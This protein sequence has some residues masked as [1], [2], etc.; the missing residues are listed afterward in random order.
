MKKILV[1]LL[2]TLA[3]FGREFRVASYN[4]ENLFDLRKSGSEYT[5]YIP[6]T[7]YGWDDKTFSIKVKNISRVIC[8]MKPDI[9]GLQEIENDDALRALQHGVKACGW[10]MIYRAIAD[11][12]AS[13]V[14][15][16]LLSKFP[17]IEK[18]EID[19]APGKL[20]YRN[21]LEVLVDISGHR[22]RLFVNHWKSRNGG[23]SMRI[24]SA[25]A[26]MKRLMQLPKDADYIILG[27]LNSNWNESRTIRKSPRLNDTGGRT[28][29]N[30]ILKTFCDGKPVTK[31]TIHWPCHVDLWLE[32]PPQRRWSHNFYG[33]KSS[34]DHMLLPAGMFD[35]KG[36]NYLDRSFHLFR[37][38]YLFMKNGSIFRWQIAKRRHGKHLDA[39]YSDHL[40]IYAMFTTKPFS[41]KERVEA[42]K[43]TLPEAIKEIHAHI[44]D[45][46][47]M[48]IGWTNVVIDDAAVIYK[49]GRV[50]IVKEKNGRAILVYGDTANLKNGHT[51]RLG[52]QK[53]YDYRGLREVTKLRVLKDLGK[54]DISPL[55]LKR[56]DDPK[57][58]AIVN[59]VVEKIE[60]VYR[61]G[62]LYFN[63]KKI[64]VY[65]HKG[66]KRPKSGEK[67][68]LCHV[69]I[70][71]YRNRPE[72]VVE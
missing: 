21:I 7:G 44:A 42:P 57:D 40:P 30:D 29:I 15:T 38:N 67:I 14:K 2:F 9:I 18:R 36:V 61:R 68:V 54:R 55:L 4:V 71:L 20:R 46:Y 62:Y 33:M 13:T 10:T 59:E 51:Y 56:I 37:P 35:A 41:L 3:L 53:I 69:R 17:I 5:E 52:I 60:G 22:V 32:L 47:T 50:A 12:K 1:F 48:P 25:K 27:D 58:L 63:G 11:T 43:E 45:L 28:G 16:A 66:I 70:G 72:I 26:L 6:Y 39:G 23:E 49:K 8:D 34:L 24:V 65:Y 19:P 31:R 64:K